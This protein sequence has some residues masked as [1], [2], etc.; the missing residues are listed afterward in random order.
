M[1]S[2]FQDFN[3]GILKDNPVLV[4]ALGLC[5]ALAVTTSLW[6][7]LGMGLAVIFVLLCSNVLISISRKF[8]PKKERIPCFIVIIATFVTLTDWSMNA[9]VPG[10][11]AQLGLFVPLIVVNCLVLGRAEAFASKNGLFR[12][13]L[14]ALGMGLGFTFALALMGGIREGLG[15]G[16]LWG[17]VV[18]PPFKPITLLILPAGGFLTLGALLGALAW[19]EHRKLDAGITI[20]A[21]EPLLELPKKEAA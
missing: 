19:R 10:L 4:Q 5:P 8:I 2:A 11:H 1:S 7:G 15:A 17:S 20:P 3:R 16:T 14:D 9:F 12:S 18:L 21:D 13:V 6:N